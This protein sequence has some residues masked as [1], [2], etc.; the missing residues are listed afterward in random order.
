MN[1]D[2]GEQFSCQCLFKVIKTRARFVLAIIKKWRTSPAAGL[3]IICN[4]D[5]RLAMNLVGE[6]DRTIGPVL[7]M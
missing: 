1:N 5:I 2:Q 6:G 7:Y 3:V 4:P